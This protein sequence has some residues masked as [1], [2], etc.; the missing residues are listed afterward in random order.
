MTIFYEQW[1][2]IP[3]Y[4]GYEIV[5]SKYYSTPNSVQYNFRGDRCIVTLRSWKNFN[6]YP[7]G[8]V[9]PYFHYNSRKKKWKEYYELT[10]LSNK[11]DRITI[12]AIIRLIEDYD[13]DYTTEQRIPN[14]GSRNRV[15]MSTNKKQILA[16]T[17][18]SEQILVGDLNASKL[19]TKKKVI[20]KLY[21]EKPKEA[22]TFY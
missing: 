16:A 4:N 3:Q 22:I 19:E 6:Q 9:L 8:Y 11:R 5:F 2:R 20:P 15:R 17:A 21:T 12:H 18:L 13:L 7:N 14:P 1:Y 10:N